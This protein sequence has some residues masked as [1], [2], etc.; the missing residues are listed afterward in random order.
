MKKLITVFLATGLLL[1]SVS[2]AQ[3][4][5]AVPSEEVT[6]DKSRQIAEEFVKNSPTFVFDGIEES[7]VLTNTA[8]FSSKTISPAN[9]QASPQ[10]LGWVFTFEFDSRQAGYGDRT[11]QVLAQVITHHVAEITVEEL[12]VTTAVM[13]DQWDMKQQTEISTHTESEARQIAEDFVKNSPTF[14][15]DGIEDSLELVETLYP[16]IENAWQFV[17]QFES[18]QAGYGDRT[19]QILAEVIT[20]HEAIITVEQGEVTNAIMDEKWDMITQKLIE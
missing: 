20:P 2:C 7:L 5:P 3:E 9:D 8:A 11:G 1:V 16:D 4:S 14:R 15:F 18:R 10:K 6:Q 13:D 17:F 19:G 12:E